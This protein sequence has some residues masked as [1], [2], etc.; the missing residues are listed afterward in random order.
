MPSPMHSPAPLSRGCGTTRLGVTQGSQCALGAGS[1]GL[2]VLGKVPPF[3]EGTRCD[4][5]PSTSPRSCQLSQRSVPACFTSGVALP[6]DKQTNKQTKSRTRCWEVKR[7]L[8][9]QRQPPGKGLPPPAPDE[10]PGHGR[11]AAQPPQR[12]PL[13]GSCRSPWPTAGAGGGD[14]TRVSLSPMLP[15][16]PCPGAAAV[17]AAW[18]GF[19][20]EDLG[21]PGIAAR[22][23]RG[24]AGPVAVP[25]QGAPRPPSSAAAAEA[26][27]RLLR[28]CRAPAAAWPGADKGGETPPL[29]R[30]VGARGRAGCCLSPLPA[31]AQGCTVGRRTK[32][33][34]C[35]IKE[36]LCG[37][38]AKRPA[39]CQPLPTPCPPLHAPYLS[40][41]CPQR[42]H[43]CSHCAHPCLRHTPP[44]P[45]RAH[46]QPGA[47]GSLPCPRSCRSVLGTSQ[48]RRMGSAGEEQGSG[49][50]QQ[51]LWP[52]ARREGQPGGRGA[53]TGRDRAGAAVAVWRCGC[54]ERPLARSRAV[55]MGTGAGSGALRGPGGER[56]SRPGA[57]PR[58]FPV[59]SWFCIP[60]PARPRAAC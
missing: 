55:A 45:A 46:L 2:K 9:R 59:G 38:A 41:P 53:G 57:G 16:S 35:F 44:C 15:S 47:A 48:G 49:V 42:V 29:R 37:H 8:A 18:S 33:L 34:S 14:G 6:A 13:P 1:L 7:R 22:S 26:L 58:A 24:Q 21:S 20:H 31:A 52:A 60:T 3:L 27:P 10:P 28:R 4:P 19:R 11:T 17:P 25:G 54:P 50:P 12:S 23:Q 30:G 39:G 43:P 56:G 40:L 32:P 36:G 5:L 51:R